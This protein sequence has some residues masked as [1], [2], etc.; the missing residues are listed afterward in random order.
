MKH[1]LTLLL[2]SSIII[3][4]E[5]IHS[6]ISSYY[7]NK[8]FSNSVQKTDGYVIGVGAD[9][10]HGS[11][12]YKFT[13]EHIYTNTIQPPMSDDLKVDK[14]FFRYAYSFLD[15]FELNLNYINI[16]SDN[17]ALTDGGKI[18]AVGIGYK[19]SKKLSA[20]FTQYYS[21]YKDFNVY[22]SDLKLDFKMKI[23]KV[24]VKFSSYSK[25]IN[26]DDKNQNGFTKNA[27]K[28]YI[29]TGLKFHMHYNTYHF[30]GGAYF[31]K[32]AFG[33]MNDGFKIQHHALEFDRTYAIGAGKNISDFVLRLQYINQRAIEMPVANNKK[34]TISVLRA[35]LNY[36]F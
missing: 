33:V 25:Y 24:K 1:I 34:I 20:N 13:Y 21:D 7:E 5:P 6:S 10:H 3:A 27:Q 8:T 12:E 28:D 11:S 23:K 26:I 19:F 36:K 30:G 15:D 31:G 16:L 14:I 17:I 18:Y 2:L 29:T 22:Q 4:Q 32:R 9:I 35:I